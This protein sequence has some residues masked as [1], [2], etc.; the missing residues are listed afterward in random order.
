[1]KLMLKGFLSIML[2]ASGT[3]T[4]Y[5]SADSCGSNRDRDCDD[6]RCEES[7]DCPDHDG[8]VVGTKTH[9]SLRPQHSNV[10][11]RMV[12]VEDKI[13]RYGVEEF[14]GVFSVGLQYQQTFKPEKLARYLFGKQTL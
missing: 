13:H 10:A 4:W 3:V 2:L 11:R 9:F 12:A 8:D 7:I 14:N 1:M 6:R 5:A